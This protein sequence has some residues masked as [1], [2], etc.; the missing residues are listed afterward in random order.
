MWSHSTDQMIVP[1]RLQSIW[2]WHRTATYHRQTDSAATPAITILIAPIRLRSTEQMIVP[3]RLRLTDRM[4]DKLYAR[5]L[6]LPPLVPYYHPNRPLL[7][8]PAAK[9]I[10]YCLSTAPQAQRKEL[11]VWEHT[12]RL[13]SHVRPQ[14]PVTYKRDNCLPTAPQAQRKN[15]QWW[16]VWTKVT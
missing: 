2:R 10:P 14:T 11:P 8:P 5:P 9:P 1:L 4:I 16:N 12:A 7:L 13:H 3:V 6:S 15:C